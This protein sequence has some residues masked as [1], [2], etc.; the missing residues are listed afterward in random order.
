VSNSI[1]D[2]V[3]KG[4]IKDK[5]RILVTHGLHL[6]DKCDKVIVMEEGRIV[7]NDTPD[8]VK[9]DENFIRIALELEIQ[10]S[11]AS[12][13]ELPAMPAPEMPAPAMEEIH[14]PADPDLPSDR[15]EVIPMEAIQTQKLPP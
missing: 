11:Q 3:L 5:T 6:L 8:V 7:C 9:Q 12:V 4:K 13:A 14:L 15:I 1:F 2:D 10:I